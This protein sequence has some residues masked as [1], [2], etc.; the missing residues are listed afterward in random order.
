MP[1]RALMRATDLVK[2]TAFMMAMALVIALLTN[3][4]GVF[5]SDVLTTDVRSN[6][7][8]LILAVMM[9]L[10]L[11]RYRFSN[12]NPVT[13]WRSVGRALLMGLV[14]SSLIPLAGY[15]LLRDTQWGA[16][17]AGLVF[18]AAT[19][20]AASVAPLSYILRGDMEH[21][22]RGT[23][24]VYVAS[25]VWI[26]FVV[27]LAMGESVDMMSLVVTVVE[28]IGIPLAVS[29]LLTR[30]EISRDAMSMFLNCCIFVLVWLSVGSTNFSTSTAGILAAFAVIAALRS[31]GLGSVI[32]TVERRS[33]LPWG[34]RVADILM[35]SY[36]NKGIAIALCAATMGPEAP[37][38]MVAVATSIVVEISWV[39][40]MDSVLFSRRRMERELAR[41]AG[42]V[43]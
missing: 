7:T 28:I 17:A 6:L 39:I 4:A 18:I 13:H 1:I 40:F 2:S 16:E 15:F 32:E 38:A 24:Y 8:V 37:L 33:G 26:P 22:A 41:D 19:P 3:L 9:T 34:Q 31:F 12:L 43:S 27:W 10:S 21:A 23:V 29:R 5:P 11:S 35:A 36:K 25:L 30:F 14:V 20:F 42:E